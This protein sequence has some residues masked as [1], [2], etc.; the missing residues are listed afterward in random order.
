MRRRKS[1]LSSFAQ[2]AHGRDEQNLASFT[3]RGLDHFDEPEAARQSLI[4]GDEFLV[5]GS[6]V[7]PMIRCRHGQGDLNML[8][9][10]DDVPRAAPARDGLCFIENRIRFACSFAC[11]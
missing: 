2:G 10:S 9:A 4:F 6:V 1:L 5:L 11:Q 3:D 8:A 7:A